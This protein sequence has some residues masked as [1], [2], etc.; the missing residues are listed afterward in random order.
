MFFPPPPHRKGFE[1]ATLSELNACIHQVNQKVV[2]LHPTELKFYLGVTVQTTLITNKQNLNEEINGEM[3]YYS[4]LPL[5]F[6]LFIFNWYI[7]LTDIT[8]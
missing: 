2:Q 6:S 7:V 1:I 5:H 3:Q 8:Q 4:H